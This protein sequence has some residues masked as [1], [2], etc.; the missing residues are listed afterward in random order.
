MIIYRIFPVRR[1]L[2]ENNV[3]SFWCVLHNVYKVKFIYDQPTQ[4]RIAALATILACTPSLLYLISTPNNKQ[5]LLS[6]FSVS[7]SFFMFSF[8]VHEKQIL[9]P[10]LFFG[11]LIHDFR[12]FFSVFVTVT[13]FSMAKLYTMDK[14]HFIYPPLMIGSHYFFKKLE[15]CLINEFRLGLTK[16]GV[17]VYNETF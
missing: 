6:L 2:F 14:N 7:M 5:F 15:A 9:L 8:H 17:I 3:A 1:G 13:N 4:I 12:H 16:S 10:L 11:I